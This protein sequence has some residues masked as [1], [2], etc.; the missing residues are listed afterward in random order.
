MVPLDTALQRI[1]E[2]P[3]TTR[4]PWSI[5]TQTNNIQLE[6]QP[7]TRW[8]FSM[9]HQRHQ[10][11]DAEQTNKQKNKNSNIY[12]EWNSKE[13]GQG[14][15]LSPIG[16]THMQLQTANECDQRQRFGEH[17]RHLVFS[18]NLLDNN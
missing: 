16:R 4:L 12:R 7:P 15:T 13:D 2:I 14:I 11:V 8:V 10:Q 9:V 3:S 18:I 17:I 6:A 1:I 5:S